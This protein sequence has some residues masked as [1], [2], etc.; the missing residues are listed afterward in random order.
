MTEVPKLWVLHVS[1]WSERAKWALDHHGI[2]Y[3]LVQHAP[4]LGERRLRKLVGASNGPVTVPVLVVGD[5]VITQSWDIAVWADEHGDGTK[6][7]PAGKE[8]AIRQ[9]VQRVDE[10]SRHGRALVVGAQ[11]QS[12]GALDESHPPAIPSFI[13]PL[14]RPVTRYG[15]RWFARKY[16]LAL[17]GVE[18][19]EQAMRDALA[20]LRE[21]LG[22]GEY[23]LGDFTYADIA[24]ATMLQGIAPVGDEYIR[25][26]PA[27]RKVWTQPKLA[28]E[29]VD[30]IRWRDELYREH[31][32]HRASA[33]A[34]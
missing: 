2:E 22:S 21:G 24:V 11:L 15:T 4:F 3:R 33:S 32:R 6:L 34:G 25:L 17:D 20:K 18:A 12:P 29:F 27:T 5:R 26:G 1:P 8:A 23:L 28:S 16:G 19:H 9:W 14:L 30:L 31:R 7:I 10:A 13:R